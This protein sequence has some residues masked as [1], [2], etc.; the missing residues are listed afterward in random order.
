MSLQMRPS[1]ESERDAYSFLGHLMHQPAIFCGFD[2]TSMAKPSVFAMAVDI[3]KQSVRQT[4]QDLGG[5]AILPNE[6]GALC[7]SMVHNDGTGDTYDP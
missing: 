3:E 6:S 4:L 1:A 2:H 7:Q 5:F